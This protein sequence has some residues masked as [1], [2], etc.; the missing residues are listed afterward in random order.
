MISNKLG[1]LLNLFISIKNGG[2]RW[3][4]L[5]FVLSLL[6]ILWQS[7]SEIFR[8]FKGVCVWWSG[9]FRI[10]KSLKREGLFCFMFIK[11]LKFLYYLTA[12]S[13]FSFEATL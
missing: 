4:F 1:V 7:S 10:E 12:D 13:L 8:S 2:G 11:S 9:V 6:N 5:S 3:I